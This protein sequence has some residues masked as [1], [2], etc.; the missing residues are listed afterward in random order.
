MIFSLFAAPRSGSNY[1]KGLLEKNYEI[2]IR[3]DETEWRHCLFTKNN[4]ILKAPYTNFTIIKDPLSWLSSFYNR[5]NTKRHTDVPFQTYGISFKHFIYHKM[6][7]EDNKTK[8][9]ETFKT[10]IEIYMA[11]FEKY[12]LL[13]D[14]IFFYEDLIEDFSV[15]ILDFG[16]KYNLK[17]KQNKMLPVEKIALPSRYPTKF[18]NQNFKPSYYKEKKYL[19]KFTQEDINFVYDKMEEYAEIATDNGKDFDKTVLFNKVFVKYPKPT[20]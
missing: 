14:F 6:F 12:T 2:D 9:K 3:L 8:K 17:K 4:E 19:E 13:C 7:W 20:M 18:S 5:Q 15:P 10:P 1:L 11:F 16:D